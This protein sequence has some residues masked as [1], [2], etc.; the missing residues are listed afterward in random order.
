[1]KYRVFKQI[2]MNS[3]VCRAVT[4]NTGVTEGLL[5]VVV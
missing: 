4:S 1:M 5:A 3:V 2:R